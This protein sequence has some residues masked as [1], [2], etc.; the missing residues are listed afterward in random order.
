[1]FSHS[2][3]KDNIYGEFQFFFGEFQLQQKSNYKKLKLF[4][5]KFYVCYK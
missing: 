4:G 3:N 2:S 1:M 5:I